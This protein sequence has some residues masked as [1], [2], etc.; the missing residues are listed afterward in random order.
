[1]FYKEK[2]A[3]NLFLMNLREEPLTYRHLMMRVINLWLL[4]VISLLGKLGIGL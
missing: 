1:M 3:H 4:G 2:M